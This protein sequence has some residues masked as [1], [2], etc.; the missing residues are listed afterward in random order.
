MLTK[1]KMGTPRVRPGARATASAARPAIEPTPPAVTQAPAGQIVIR[2]AVARPARIAPYPPQFQRVATGVLDDM[3]RNTRIYAQA[4]AEA[5]T[6]NADRRYGIGMAAFER[7]ADGISSGIM[8]IV[9]YDRGATLPS[10]G[11][12][13][14]LQGIGLANNATVWGQG[15]TN[16]PF[17]ARELILGVR[18]LVARSIAST[19]APQLVTPQM[20]FAIPRFNLFR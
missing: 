19:C 9:R 13:P 2:G 14:L 17:T 15:G 8:D 10:P 12:N 11:T 7:Y 3:A 18:D 16:T 5:R 1:A 4:C 20:L 6:A